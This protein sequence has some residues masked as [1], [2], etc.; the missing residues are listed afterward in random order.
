MNL[1]SNCVVKKLNDTFI[2]LLTP[3]TNFSWLRVSSTTRGIMNKLNRLRLHS[4]KN[5][6]SCVCTCQTTSFRSTGHAEVRPPS[7]TH[8]C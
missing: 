6:S 8:D 7:S 2:L 1:M 4:E 5:K 3:A